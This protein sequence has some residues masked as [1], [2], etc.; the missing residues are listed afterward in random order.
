MKEK[1][2]EAYL[3]REI[4]NRGGTCEKFTSP[5]RRSVP[6]RICSMRRGQIFYV[7]VKQPGEEATPAQRRDHDRRRAR[8]FHVFVIDTKEGVDYLL[9]AQLWKGPI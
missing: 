1:V 9:T 8:G 3:V 7:E 4:E 2:V 6:D 5:A